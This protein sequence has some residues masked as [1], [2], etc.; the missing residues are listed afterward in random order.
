MTLSFDAWKA[1]KVLPATVEVPTIVH[2]VV[3]SPELFATLSGPTDGIRNIAIAPD[4]KTFAT[5]GRGGDVKLW[6]TESRKERGSLRSDLGNPFNVG[7]TPDGRILAVSYISPEREKAGGVGLWDMASAKQIGTLRNRPL[8]NVT[9]LVIAPD[10]KTLVASESWRD[11]EERKSEVAVWDIGARKLR[12]VLA[13]EH[14]PLALSA[15]GTL[16]A[17][18]FIIKENRVSGSE[19]KRWDVTTLK[20]IPTL[21]PPNGNVLL[22]ARASPDGKTLATSTPEGAIYLWDLAA[23]KIRQTIRP[24]VKRLAHSLAFAP[25]SKTLAAALSG[26]QGQENEPGAIAL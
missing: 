10:G 25:D 19:I 13:V 16:S 26:R 5:S 21:K 4:G 23:A 14:S 6:D 15:D 1:A 8:A 18:T 7:F 11:G 9:Q 24:E 20:E 17:R 12:G 3:E 2:D 22:M